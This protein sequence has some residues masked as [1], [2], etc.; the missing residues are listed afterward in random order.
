VYKDDEPLKTHCGSPEYAAPELFDGTKTYGP[1]I[2]IW[3]LYVLPH[4]Y[5]TILSWAPAGAGIT[6]RALALPWKMYT[7]PDS[8]RLH[9]F[10]SHKKYQNQ[11]TF[12]GSKYTEIATA[13]GG[14]VPDLITAGAYSVP[15]V[16][17]L[18]LY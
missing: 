7:K 14:C 4:F 12:H 2:D 15:T 16:T 10:G 1:E 9:H 17:D 13:A 3:S 11:G 18:Q 8:F 5:Y 6:R